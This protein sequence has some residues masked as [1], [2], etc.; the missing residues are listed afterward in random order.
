MVVPTDGRP[1]RF[2]EQENYYNVI[3]GYKDLLAKSIYN[4]ICTYLGF[5]A[6]Q[7]NINATDNVNKPNITN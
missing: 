3:N 1:K 6:K 5:N 4:G 7:I 2:L